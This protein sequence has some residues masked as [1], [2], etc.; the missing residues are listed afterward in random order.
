MTI[1]FRYILREYAK[2]FF[3]CFAGLMTIYL[4]IDFFE[5]I[6]RFLRYDSDIISMLTYF[7]LKIPAI[8]FQIAPFAI[9][10]ATLL[11]L[12]LLSR[13][14]EITAMR[15]CGI[16]LL[17]ITS[18]FLL[19]AT[20]VRRFRDAAAARGG[21]PAEK[22]SSH[23][24]ED[25]IEAF[26]YESSVPLHRGRFEKFLRRLPSELY[27]AK[28]LLYFDGDDWSSIFNY[29]CGRYDIDWFQKKGEIPAKSQAVFIGKHLLSYK[30]RILTGL[31][32][33]GLSE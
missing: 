15:C 27:R 11:T 22:Q 26:T 2:I 17:W 31:V 21:S 5:K 30:E 8:S 4:V 20:G 1:L 6:R 25:A 23:L 24:H 3:M 9:L 29:T 12:G 28:G 14:N 18:P 16:S 13:S 10:M 19:F 33:C 7:A 32:K